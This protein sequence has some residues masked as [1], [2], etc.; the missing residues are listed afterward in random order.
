MFE[1]R[2]DKSMSDYIRKYIETSQISVSLSIANKTA[3]IR[4]K[5]EQIKMKLNTDKITYFLFFW[6][7][8]GMIMYA[9]WKTEV[10]IA[11]DAIPNK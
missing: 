6:K 4:V 9:V 7:N 5:T 1:N 8:N 2:P 3:W 11:R 10:K